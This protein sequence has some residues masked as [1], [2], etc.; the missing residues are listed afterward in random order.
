MKKNYINVL[1][2]I[3]AVLIATAIVYAI[4]ST[5]ITNVQNGSFEA[6][7]IADIPNNNGFYAIADAQYA[8][9]WNTTATD[10]RIELATPYSGTSSA[11]MKTPYKITVE[12]TDGPQYAEVNANEEA[13][14][15]QNISTEQNKVYTWSITHRGSGPSLTDQDVL[16]V[17]IGNSQEVSPSKNSDGKDQFML[18][19]EWI[20]ENLDL[21]INDNSM[22]DL[23]EIYSKPFV[24]DGGFE[25]DA[26]IS[27]FSS[28]QDEEHTQL[29]KIR[30]VSSGVKEW[31][32]YKQEYRSSSE[33]TLFAITAYST[34]NGQNT[35]GNIIDNVQFRNAGN[36]EM[37]TNGSF[38]QVVISSGC[39]YVSSAN[40]D[41][42]PENIGWNSTSIE[43]KI[44]I[45][46]FVDGQSQ[47]ING[48]GLEIQPNVYCPDG[49]Q[50]GELN[51]NEESTLYQYVSTIG[52]KRY[53]W[54]LYHRGRE[55][56]DVMALII[57]SKQPYDPKKTGITSQDQL[58]RMVEWVKNQSDIDIGIDTVN[59]GPEA[60]SKK[61]ILYSTPFADNGQYENNDNPFSWTK[62]ET[63]T[64]EWSIWIMSSEC[65]EWHGYGSCSEK[66][67]T[68]D[69]T[70][71]IPEGIDEALFAFVSY[72]SASTKNSI[73]NLI[74]AV[75]VE[76][77][78][79]VECYTSPSGSGTYTYLE[80]DIFTYDSNYTGYVKANDKFRISVDPQNVNKNRKFIG[81]RING[82]FIGLD[83]FVENEN[84][85]LVYESPAVL[86][87]YEVRLIYE[88]RNIIYDSNGGD[89]Y[90]Y[91][92]D[93]LT[94]GYEVP[95]LPSEIYVSHPIQKTKE[96]G[97]KDDGWKFI[98]WQY[99]K[100]QVLFDGVHKVEYVYEDNTNKYLKIYQDSDGKEISNI[101]LDE[102]VTM[103]AQWE[104]KNT[105]ITQVYDPSKDEYVDSNLGGIIN[106]AFSG[107]DNA[108]SQIT[109][110]S[111]AYYIKEKTDVSAQAIVSNAYVFKGWYN[112]NNELVSATPTYK[113][114]TEARKTET[115]YARFD[116]TGVSLN[117]TKVVQ[118]DEAENN[119]YFTITLNIEKAKPSTKYRLVNVDTNQLTVDG[120]NVYNDQAIQTDTVGR[121]TA[122]IYIKSN[123]TVIIENL[124]VG[125]TYSISEKDYVG[126]GYYTEIDSESGTINDE[127]NVTI[128]NTRVALG[129]KV[130]KNGLQDISD[131]SNTIPLEGTE[132]S[133][134]TDS[135][136]KNLYSKIVTNSNGQNVFGK[137]LV[138]NST[139]YLKE[140]K[141]VSG[142]QI[143]NN[144]YKIVSRE[145]GL[146]LYTPDN[147]GVYTTGEK[148]T[149]D[150]NQ[151]SNVTFTNVIMINIPYSGTIFTSVVFNCIGIILV[152][153]SILGGVYL[154]K[155]NSKA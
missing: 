4:E 66:T 26:N 91:I 79:R 134:Y 18:M 123:Q 85:V 33:S 132:Y 135:G 58:M 72:K 139:Y 21:T 105:F 80:D 126:S 11:H 96:D 27:D 114:T 121:S 127:T 154:K 119:R 14:I 83:Q 147:N 65:T 43:K 90:H 155:I 136:C 1:I 40:S 117:I 88:A 104:Y 110:T 20:K 68:Y 9:G 118:G 51:A 48:D 137:K 8:P 100:D 78:Y 13:T 52:G 41:D 73:G 25:G 150:E 92:E 76:E 99:E 49:Q 144:V 55:G 6:E 69:N 146:Y 112:S 22:T 94:T 116:P 12:Q 84:G 23:I 71:I 56:I 60:C 57:G 44:E 82:E 37:L 103:V 45:G 16:A 5:E 64:Q 95:L 3:V 34:T 10:N 47:H 35:V 31:Y 138:M 111:Q 30:I 2:I 46:R 39:E 7:K 70:Y 15:Y 131:I 28:S 107:K 89:D 145:D 32:K 77:N 140:T 87:H 74:D 122:Q 143:D 86:Q 81:A 125:A 120:E 97:T 63:Y 61:I 36:R 93:D 53:D 149:M 124:P 19:V 153:I 113:Y 152:I 108:E 62:D 148:L 115:L 128:T 151:I 133:L 50:F 38:E 67:T 106:V 101:S 75:K 142:Y 130:T 24:S 102:G 54:G 109:D 17:I 141:V 59:F 129:L 98:G 42:A 29:W